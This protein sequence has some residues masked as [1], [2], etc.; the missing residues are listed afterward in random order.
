V[1]FVDTTDVVLSPGL[2]WIA[3]MMSSATNTTGIGE[4]TGAVN[5]AWDAGYRF[6]EDTANPLPATATPVESSNARWWLF[7]FSTTT[8]T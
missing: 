1:Q 5:P 3:L 7:G 8:I 4:A 6:Q 2:W